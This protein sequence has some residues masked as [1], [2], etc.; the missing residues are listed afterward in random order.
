MEKS[1]IINLEQILHCDKDATT[2]SPYHGFG[3]PG[4]E[5]N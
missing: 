3:R 2:L 1:E 4:A 5:S